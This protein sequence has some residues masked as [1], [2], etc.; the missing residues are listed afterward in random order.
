MSATTTS[1]T[2]PEIIV[3]VHGFLGWGEDKGGNKRYWGFTDITKDKLNIDDGNKRNLKQVIGKNTHLP[4]YVASISP[5][6]SNRERACELYA[7][8]R[9]L[10]TFYGIKRCAEIRSEVVV[11]DKPGTRLDFSQPGNHGGGWL[12]QWGRKGGGKI[13]F[14]GH[15]MGGNTIR[16]LERLIHHGDENEPRPEDPYFD[17]YELFATDK[18]ILHDRAWAIKSIVTIASPHDGSPLPDILGH[19]IA[20]FISATIVGAAVGA[21][22]LNDAQLIGSLDLERLGVDSSHRN[23]MSQFTEIHDRGFLDP[24][25]PHLAPCDLS[26]AWCE[27]FNSTP[28]RPIAYPET[29]YFAIAT[30]KSKPTPFHIIGLGGIPDEIPHV[31]MNPILHPFCVMAGKKPKPLPSN[32]R[33]EFIQNDGQVTLRSSRGPHVQ[34][35]P[36]PKHLNTTKQKDHISHVDFHNLVP[37][38][39]HYVDFDSC[40]HFQAI[41]L[42]CE[43]GQLEF[44]YTNICEFINIVN[45]RSD[46]KN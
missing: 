30:A 14:I 18:D 42:L 12:P 27:K 10:R 20:S 17:G 23:I 15:S 22:H 8:I 35:Q 29:W 24:E 9:G 16:M 40:D 39:W 11:S 38:Q 25:Y 31:R 34:G 45:N 5:A 33:R 6:S 3:L 43:H 28:D 4:V 44:I 26:I 2:E 37:G 13:H 7:Q 46:G 1:T 32:F 19:H 21:A 36:E 41:G